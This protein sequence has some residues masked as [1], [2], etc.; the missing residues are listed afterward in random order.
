PSVAAVSGW[1]V[2]RFERPRGDHSARRGK[3]RWIPV[4]AET[5]QGRQFPASPPLPT[6]VSPVAQLSP[7]F[8]WRR[9]C[10]TS[11]ESSLT[12]LFSELEVWQSPKKAPVTAPPVAA[13]L[14]ISSPACAVAMLRPLFFERLGRT[15]P[16]I[17]LRRTEW[18]NSESDSSRSSRGRW[19]MRGKR[20]K[21]SASDAP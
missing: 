2:R 5:G 10:P 16:S 12:C 21:G 18:A 9:K 17:W 19:K 13:F 3:E 15:V 1:C 4:P 6:E 11:R 7:Q 14:P 8:F 20:A